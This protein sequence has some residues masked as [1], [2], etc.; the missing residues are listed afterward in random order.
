MNINLSA[1]TIHGFKP[2]FE[3]HRMIENIIEMEKDILSQNV[4]FFPGGNTNEK[5]QHI[6]PLL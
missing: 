4:S 1:K 2:S 6:D 5:N 3:I